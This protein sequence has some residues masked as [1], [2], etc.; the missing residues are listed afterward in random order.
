MSFLIIFFL[1]LN[2]PEKQLHALGKRIFV[3]YYRV[4]VESHSDSTDNS[5]CKLKFKAFEIAKQLP[6]TYRI[7]H[8][9]SFYRK[10]M[11]QAFGKFHKYFI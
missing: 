9:W 3:F 1:I 10:F 6:G 5:K 2:G 11:K 8:E 4:T 7:L